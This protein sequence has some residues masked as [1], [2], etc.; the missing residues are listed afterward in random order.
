MNSHHH[1]LTVI[2]NI[3]HHAGDFPATVANHAALV[4]SKFSHPFGVHHAPQKETRFVEEPL[5]IGYAYNSG[6]FRGAPA[7]Q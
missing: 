1:K 2:K 6:S 7:P 5:D 3:Q 4:R